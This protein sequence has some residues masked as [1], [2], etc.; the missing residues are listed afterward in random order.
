[1]DVDAPGGGGGRRRWPP[2]RPPP[3]HPVRQPAVAH[4]WRQRRWRRRAA[5]APPPAQWVG[6][7]LLPA[8]RA[9]HPAPP[10]PPPPLPRPPAEGW[11]EPRAGLA[12]GAKAK[13]PP[14]RGGAPTEAPPFSTVPHPKSPAPVG[15]RGESQGHWQRC[16]CPRVPLCSLP[17]RPERRP[18]Q[19]VRAEA[20]HDATDLRPWAQGNP[21][22]THKQ[23]PEQRPPASGATAHAAPWP[24]PHVPPPP[25]RPV[26]YATPPQNG[27]LRRGPPSPANAHGLGARHHEGRRHSCAVRGWRLGEVTVSA[28]ATKAVACIPGVDEL[29]H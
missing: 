10:A 19:H 3:R 15:N 5:P 6:T 26:R 2:R 9:L 20:G 4:L 12:G 25:V 13:G 1:M 11:L 18:S 16:T 23:P 21:Q 22:A 27:R 28:G 17:H 7:L 14:V 8:A 29:P 24:P